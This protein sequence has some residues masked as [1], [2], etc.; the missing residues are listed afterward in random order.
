M[1]YVWL[2]TEAEF[3]MFMVMSGNSASSMERM[4]IAFK[5]VPLGSFRNDWMWNCLDV[6][7][8]KQNND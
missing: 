6:V 8:T 1:Q 2:L 7:R 3:D 4:I 5:K